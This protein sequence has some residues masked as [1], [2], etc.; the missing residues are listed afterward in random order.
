VCLLTIASFKLL[1]GLKVM[2]A[3]HLSPIGEH[4]GHDENSRAQ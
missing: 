2:K 3:F 1:G 4:I